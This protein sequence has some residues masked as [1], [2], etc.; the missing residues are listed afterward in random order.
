MPENDDFEL[1]QNRGGMW[2][3][4]MILVVGVGA[5]LTFG[6]F[7]E[8]PHIPL[9]GMKALTGYPCPGCG[10]TRAVVNLGG[11]NLAASWHFHPLGVI[12][13][14]ALAATGLGAVTGLI[15]G[16]D[17]VWRLFAAKGHILMVLFVSA[18][19]VIW[20]VR[21]FVV[22]EWSPDPIPGG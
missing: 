3:R 11:L 15:T 12:V 10:M 7:V 19:F 8:L 18:L 2:L 14:G 1:P 22:P 20:I 13:V 9:C 6:H 4:L 5:A 16:R 17:P 21:V